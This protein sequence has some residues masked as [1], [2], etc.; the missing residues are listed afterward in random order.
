[1]LASA[2]P[3]SDDS[4]V[5]AWSTTQATVLDLQVVPVAQRTPGPPAVEASAGQLL[6]VVQD[7][8]LGHVVHL[9]AGRPDAQ[10]PVEVLAPV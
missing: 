7:L 1:M 3:A 10:A 8:R 4:L 9:Q 5:Q 6:E 2:A